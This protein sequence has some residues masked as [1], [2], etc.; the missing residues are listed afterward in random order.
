MSVRQRILS[1][2]FTVWALVAV[3]SC[4]TGPS[5][6]SGPTPGTPVA[7]L[8]DADAKFLCQQF[9]TA[10]CGSILAADDVA[11]TTCQPC[12]QATTVATIRGE[13]GDGITTG[14]VQH[15]I[16]SGFDMPTCTGPERGGCMFDVA[17]ALCPTPLAP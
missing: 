15:C 16:G 11:C 6:H 5:C 2:C 7:E 3:A 13:C 17:D 12:A 8:G 1:S 9:F 10:A 4:D 14:G